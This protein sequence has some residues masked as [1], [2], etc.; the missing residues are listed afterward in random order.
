MYLIAI[1][2]QV[3]KSRINAIIP[4][5][6][7]QIE[8]VTAMF[9]GDK[10]EELLAGEAAFILDC[11]DDVPTKADLLG[12]CQSHGLR[13]ICSLGAALKAD[14]TRICIGDLDHTKNEPLASKLRYRIKK[15][16]VSH[17][18]SD[19]RSRLWSCGGIAGDTVK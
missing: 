5:S 2:L 4:P 6:L 9:T 7:C 19:G 8:A 13:V 12:Y 10:A 18:L 3:L 17:R 11:I 15:N 1:G 14:P 16:G